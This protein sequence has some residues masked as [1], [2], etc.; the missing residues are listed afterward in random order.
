MKLLKRT[1]EVEFTEVVES[2]YNKY[3]NLKRYNTRGELSLEYLHDLAEACIRCSCVAFALIDNADVMYEY[4]G[5]R[6]QA[7][8]LIYDRVSRKDLC[9]D[10]VDYS[11]IVKNEESINH[12]LDKRNSL[13]L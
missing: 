2:L 4:I 12:L 7:I 13:G 5:K 1:N 6:N 11:F 9:D 3:K 8:A 10:S